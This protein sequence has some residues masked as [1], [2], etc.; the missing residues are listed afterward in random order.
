MFVDNYTG[1]ASSTSNEFESNVQCYQVL[2]RINMYKC[3]CTNALSLIIV[4]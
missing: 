4:L 3:I 1:K 2:K